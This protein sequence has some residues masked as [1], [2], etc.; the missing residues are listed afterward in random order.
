VT[1]GALIYLLFT[2]ALVVA[3]AG[4]VRH[5]YSP[6]RRDAVEAPKHR[7]LRDD[8]GAPG[9]DRRNRP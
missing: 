7:M 5:Y 4:I 9:R 6:K 1:T 3:F 8:D 2:A